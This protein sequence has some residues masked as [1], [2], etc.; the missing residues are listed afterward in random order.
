MLRLIIEDDEGKTTVVPL[1]RDEITIGRK[2]GNTIRLTERNVSRRH[3]RLVR[4]GEGTDHTI[5]VEDLDSYNGIKLNGDKVAGKCTMRPGDLVQIGDYS[6]ALQVDPP[7]GHTGD[8][9]AVKGD[10]PTIVATSRASD[11]APTALHHVDD[12][13]MLPADLRGRLVVVSSN[14]G[15]QQ[16]ELGRREIILGRTDENDVVVNHRSIS[17]NHAKIVVRDGQFTIIDLASSNGVRVN[18]EPFGTVTLVNGDIIELG[19]VK[20]RFVAPGEHYVFTP[21]D[22]DDVEVAGASGNTFRL[23]A[24]ALVLAGIAIGTFFLVRPN[25]PAPPDPKGIAGVQSSNAPMSDSGPVDVARLIAEG[26]THLSQEAWTDAQ[27]VFDRAL[28]AT[29][30]N[31]QARAGRERAATESANQHN[32]DDLR[33][34]AAESQWADAYM[35]L[36]K[37][38]TGSVYSPRAQE[39]LKKI[40]PEFATS[41]LQRG[42]G[43]IEDGDIV[44]AREVQHDLATRGFSEADKLSKE[45]KAAEARKPKDLAVAA[46]PS[47]PAPATRN[48]DVATAPPSPP[49]AAEEPRRGKEDREREYESLI[50][51]GVKAMV[52]GD[53][54]AAAEFYEKAMRLNPESKVPHQRLCTIY[55]GKG[56]LERALKHCQKWLDR[57]TNN[58]YKPAIQQSIDQIK[59]ELNK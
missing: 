20:L 3:A 19:H 26:E 28:Q 9:P 40:E 8:Q 43:L 47:E 7:T 14:L 1:I 22:I 35:G 55:K 18:G 12:T 38:P 41:E 13:D 32:F 30:N 51:D 59:A 46:N 29:P 39:L 57:E 4:A 27:R 36:E 24:I 11:D 6:L 37:F 23:V 48:P 50:N 45:I 52:R 44:G 58:A 49:S 31:E 16:H 42:R 2:E 33:R 56:N 10:A 15:G 21:A 5:I 54:D 34:Q 25:K 17:R 53:R